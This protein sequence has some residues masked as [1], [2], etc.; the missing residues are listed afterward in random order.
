M[1]TIHGLGTAIRSAALRPGAGLGVSLQGLA[2]SHTSAYLPRESREESP[3]RRSL[4]SRG[5][6]TLRRRG[7]AGRESSVSL[8]L[9]AGRRGTNP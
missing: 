5:D 6:Q 9:G 2:Q 3:A 7:T 1:K 4:P 8:C